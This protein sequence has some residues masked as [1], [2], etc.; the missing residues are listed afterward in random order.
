MCHTFKMYNS[1]D[2]ILQPH[3]WKPLIERNPRERH[4][5]DVI[6]FSEN[7]FVDFMP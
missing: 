7:Q 3:T 1:V 4:F 2:K 5:E 6:L